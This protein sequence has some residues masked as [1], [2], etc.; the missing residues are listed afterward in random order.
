MALVKCL[1]CGSEVSDK[2]AA[3]PKCG[4]KMPR[5]TSRVTLLVG[6]LFAI[7]VAQMVFSSSRPDG[8]GAPA[9]PAASA[10]VSEAERA[11][12][13]RA[14]QD[15]EAGDTRRGLIAAAAKSLRAGMHDPASFEID[16]VLMMSNNAGCYTYRAKNGFGASRLGQA[17]LTPDT[18][19]VT[20][21]HS[22]F[23]A[24]WKK[25]C[26]DQKGQSLTGYVRLFVL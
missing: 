10:P 17:V 19:F 3:C 13:Q 16:E 1:E 14:A 7:F 20:S 12:L 4:A 23:G 15:K 2:A 9:A 26:A 24:A 8:N 11:A 25:Y 6:G 18:K 21:D 5:K 22:G